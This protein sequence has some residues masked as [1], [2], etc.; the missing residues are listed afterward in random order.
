LI[1]VVDPSGEVNFGRFDSDSPD[2]A[3]R[4]PETMGRSKIEGFVSWLRDHCQDTHEG[5]LKDA[6]PKQCDKGSGTET[7][8]FNT[9]TMSFNTFCNGRPTSGVPISLPTDATPVG[10]ETAGEPASERFRLARD[11]DAGSD[12]RAAGLSVPLVAAI[13]IQELM[14]SR[15]GCATRSQGRLRGERGLALSQRRR[16]TTAAYGGEKSAE[17]GRRGRTISDDPTRCMRPG[18]RE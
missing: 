11:G 15:C 9:E 5:M 1:S 18:H 12:G 13:A 7:H 10:T 14:A 16:R 4:V 6:T 8:L 17:Q 3:R 2:A